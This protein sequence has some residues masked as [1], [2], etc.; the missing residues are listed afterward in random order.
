[1]ETGEAAMEKKKHTHTSLGKKGNMGEGE[2]GR[3]RCGI[4]EKERHTKG[5]DRRGDGDNV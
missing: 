4:R 2:G 5:D 3:V 1:M